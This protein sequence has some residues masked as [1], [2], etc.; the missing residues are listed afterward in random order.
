M[1]NNNKITKEQII[2]TT[3][4]LIH[5][6]RSEN[7]EEKYLDFD[8]ESHDVSWNIQ[9]LC[10]EI[11]YCLQII[12]HKTSYS[13]EQAVSRLAQKYEKEQRT[14]KETTQN[15]FELYFNKKLTIG[16]VGA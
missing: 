2:Q 5:T 11:W 12:R 8:A 9:K 3:F 6:F 15:I 16:V 7:Y 14:P 13:V 1:E 10:N 4:N